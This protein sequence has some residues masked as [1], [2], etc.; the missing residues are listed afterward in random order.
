MNFKKRQQLQI[1]LFFFLQCLNIF[2]NIST[3]INQ[4]IRLEVMQGLLK[5]CGKL[6]MRIL[7]RA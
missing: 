2:N 3:F 6:G 1:F 5:T 7:Q 4:Q